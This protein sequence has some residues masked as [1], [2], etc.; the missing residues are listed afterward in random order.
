MSGHSHYATI[1]K[2][3]KAATDA[4]KGNVFSRHARNILLAA[5]GGGDPDLNFKLRVAIDKARVD[6]MPKENIERAIAKATSEGGNLEEIIYE[7]FGPAGVSVIVEA[8]TDNK[9][10]TAQEIKN[11][12]EKFGG[13]LAGPGAV[14][15]NFESKGFLLVKKS[16]DPEA[17]MLS[18]IDAGAEDLTEVED[19]I[20]VYTSPE[21]LSDLRKKLMD[22]GFEVVETELQMKPRTTVEI[23]DPTQEEKIVKFLETLEEYDD[24]QKVYSNF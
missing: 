8:A 14:S 24:V 22:A 7:G 4:A 20:E 2:R 9:N 18:L 16:A 12:F 13:T 23:T 5:K 10:R 6:N 11:L 1:N 3:Q 21:T 19:G 17:Q 15:Y